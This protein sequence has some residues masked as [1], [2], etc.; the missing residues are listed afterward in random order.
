MYSFCIQYLR[1]MNSAILVYGYEKQD[2]DTIYNA[3]SSCLNRP[4]SLHSASGNESQTIEELLTKSNNY[5]EENN[6]KIIM[7]VSI[8]NEEIHSIL[9]SFP[10]SL[11]RPIFCGLTPHNKSWTFTSL[12]EHLLEEKAYWEQQKKNKLN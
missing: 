11:I 7:F 5:F 10:T 6:P 4:I 9:N 2:V 1:I 12:K 3:I 8:E